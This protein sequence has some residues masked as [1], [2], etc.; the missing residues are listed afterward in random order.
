MIQFGDR[1]IHP[2]NGYLI[3]GKRL[4]SY[5]GCNHAKTIHKFERNGEFIVFRPI[6]TEI[7]DLQAFVVIV[8]VSFELKK[9]ATMSH[10]TF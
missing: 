7:F 3:E 2:Q 4:N 1:C 10:E 5:I 8:V 9:K 6:V